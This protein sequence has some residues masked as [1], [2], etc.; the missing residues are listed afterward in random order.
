M[1]LSDKKKKKSF[2]KK[3]GNKILKK[4]IS[5]LNLEN[6]FQKC[7]EDRQPHCQLP[8]EQ[9]AHRRRQ[10]EQ[11]R[12]RRQAHPAA[13][14]AAAAARARRRRQAG[15]GAQPRAAAASRPSPLARRGQLRPR[16][17]AHPH[18]SVIASSFSFL[19]QLP[20]TLPNVSILTNC[21]TN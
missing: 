2:E 10:D 8:A 4:F 14:G 16:L 12:V 9:S 15:R 5:N 18:T 1:I 11:E 19:I 13:A 21:S 7:W 20:N 3:N 6:S 17:A